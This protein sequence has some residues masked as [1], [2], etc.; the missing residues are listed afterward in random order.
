MD[1][2]EQPNV[3]RN[4]MIRATTYFRPK[5]FVRSSGTENDNEKVSTIK[6][7]NVEIDGSSSEF[8]NEIISTPSTPVTQN[9]KRRITRSKTK[10]IQIARE[11][12]K[13]EFDK[14]KFFKLAMSNN[15]DEMQTLINSSY[16]I[17]LNATD[18]FG[19]TA[20][21]IAS[22]EN[23]CEAFKLLLDLG[24]DLTVRDRKGNTAKSLAEKKQ[25]FSILKIIHE[26]L[27]EMKEESTYEDANNCHINEELK[28]CPD[29]G[30]EFKKSS[31][32]SH[33]SSTV[34]LFSCKYDTKCRIHSFGISRSNRG[35]QIMKRTGWDGNSGLGASG[36][37]RLHPIRTTLRK[38]KSGLGI[39]QS[40]SKVTHFKPNDLNAIRYRPPD[41]AL[42]RREIHEQSL[43]EKRQ[44]QKL[45]Q[46]LS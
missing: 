30:V 4:W 22:C 35:Y 28:V 8:Y 40:P 46:E 43:R 33:H 27:T 6:N 42:T 2:G 20:L 24:A 45:R 15:V 14:N 10:K 41:R 18:N 39:K 16:N 26:H 1:D 32:R 36:S 21:M 44:D 29:C 3:D 31:S 34:H 5:I 37:G 19:W 11:T 38:P 23:S 25:N 12:R 13:N 9:S 17:D 7:P